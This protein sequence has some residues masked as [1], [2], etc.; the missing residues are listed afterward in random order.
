SQPSYTVPFGK[1]RILCHGTDVTLIGISYM[2]VECMRAQALL[3]EIGISAEVID[4]VSLSPLDMSTI[5]NSVRKTRRLVVVDTAWTSCGV[6]AEIVARIAENMEG[7]R[8]QRIG[9]EPVTCPATKNLENLYYPNPQKVASAAF[10]MVHNDQSS[11]TPPHVDAPE[12]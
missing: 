1:A 3:S 9:Y 12:V 10:A 11:W 5:L 7:I 6:S 4:P 8:M 2:A